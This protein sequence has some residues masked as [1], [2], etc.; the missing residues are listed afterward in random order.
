M[1][2]LD[3]LERWLRPVAVPYLAPALVGIQVMVY[4]WIG[5]TSPRNPH[6]AVDRLALIPARVLEGE[7]WRPITFLAVPPMTNPIFAAF[8]WLLFAMMGMALERT[9]GTARFNLFLLIGWIVTLGASF[10]SPEQA[11]IN[12]F[13]G[14]SVFL[15]FAAINPE[16]EIRLFLVLPVK[17]KWLAYIS[18]GLIGATVLFGST[19]SAIAALASVANWFV[20]FGPE[21]ARRARNKRAVAAKVAASRKPV[22]FHTCRICGRTDLSDPGLEFR[23]CDRCAGAPCY[24]MDHL[25]DHEHITTPASAARSG[26][27]EDRRARPR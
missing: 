1:R 26:S 7:W 3:A 23:Y 22:P 21:L 13:L 14:L 27:N 25:R 5:F 16:F 20:F 24:C 15:A 6:V 18:W 2:P 10:V 9:W 8:A 17:V 19:A 12:G 11:T 4:F